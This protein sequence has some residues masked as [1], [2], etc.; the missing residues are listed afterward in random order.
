MN[1]MIYALLLSVFTA[2][3]LVPSP[4]R[5]DEAAPVNLSD[6]LNHNSISDSEENPVDDGSQGQT[7]VNDP[8]FEDPPE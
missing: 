2:M 8:G 1:K 7:I 4:A 3:V 6:D 5:A